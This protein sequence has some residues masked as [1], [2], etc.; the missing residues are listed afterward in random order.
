MKKR[1][2]F[3]VVLLALVVATLDILPG[4]SKQQIQQ[5]LATATKIELVSL[6]PDREQEDRPELFGRRQVLQRVALSD[7]E[8][9]QVR[10]SLNW[11]LRF[12]QW[13][14][15]RCFNPRHG[16]KLTTPSG[17]Y[18]L[19]ICYE[20]SQMELF[21]PDGSHGSLVP[22]NGSSQETLNGLLTGHPRT[23]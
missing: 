4:P 17:D 8:T 18:R 19:L 3:V 11:D 10:S 7:Q 14:V 1:I 23:P 22:L 20:C 13:V 2:A 15:A 16:L 12:R 9:A 5:A 6:N 21:L